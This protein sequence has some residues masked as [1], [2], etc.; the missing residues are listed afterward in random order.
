MKE[1]E[2]AR[3]NSIQQTIK[4]RAL[5]EKLTKLSKGLSRT[6]VE[7]IINPQQIKPTNQKECKLTT[8]GGNWRV[9]LNLVLRHASVDRC[10]KLV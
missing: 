2:V 6:G 3:K 8:I 9:G 5:R 7:E 4:M 1:S 10:N